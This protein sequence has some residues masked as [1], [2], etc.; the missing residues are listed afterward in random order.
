MK[1]T[2]YKR[3]EKLVCMCLI[4]AM[5]LSLS[6]II[7][8]AAG[9]RQRSLAAGSSPG[10]I[11]VGNTTFSSEED[12]TSGWED[13]KGWKNLAGQY[14]VLV[15]Y[16]GSKQEISMEGGVLTLGVAGVNRIKTLKSD[17]SINIFGTGIVLIDNIELGE[18]RHS[19]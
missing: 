7:G 13:G 12:V 3:I 14:V 2:S 1:K 17:G 11:T 18:A 15:D 16:D 19:P 10:T 4:L 9:A 8:V 6:V 5:L